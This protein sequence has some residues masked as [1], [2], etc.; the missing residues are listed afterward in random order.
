MFTIF[1]CRWFLLL[2]VFYRAHLVS[3]VHF[4]CQSIWIVQL[5]SHWPF[6][7]FLCTAHGCARSSLC[8]QPWPCVYIK[9]WMTTVARANYDMAD[10]C[11]FKWS[12]V[13]V[14]V[15]LLLSLNVWPLFAIFQRDGNIQSFLLSWKTYWKCIIKLNH[16][17]RL[18]ES[19]SVLHGIY[20]IV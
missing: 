14:V 3:L 9:L 15:F 13:C 20:A 6:V 4:L 7:H 12:I 11:S 16:N 8:K 19:F 5:M 18:C 2:F 17:F 10:D 1:C